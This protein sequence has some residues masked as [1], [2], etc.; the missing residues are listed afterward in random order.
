MASNKIVSQE[1]TELIQ[2]IYTEE[3]ILKDPEQR[4]PIESVVYSVE[5]YINEI[6][7]GEDF[8]QYFNWSND[9]EIEVL[10]ANLVKIV[11]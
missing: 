7:S 10:K 3:V 4:R 9:K 1:D 5:S 6:G 11:K 8:I 2:S